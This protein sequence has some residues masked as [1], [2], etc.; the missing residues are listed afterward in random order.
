MHTRVLSMMVLIGSLLCGA[1]VVA[2]QMQGD[3]GDASR[4]TAAGLQVA[5][6][7]PAFGGRDIHVF[8]VAV[9]RPGANGTWQFQ[10]SEGQSGIV[11]WHPGEERTTGVSQWRPDDGSVIVPR[12]AF[13]DD[14]TAVGRPES[15]EEARATA[16]SGRAALE[17]LQQA[18][19]TFPDPVGGDQLQ[20][21]IDHVALTFARAP[22]VAAG[23]VDHQFFSAI[24]DLKR[25]GSASRPEGVSVEQGV[26]MARQRLADAL[27]VERR[28]PVL[29]RDPVRR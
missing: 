3:A 15:I 13:F 29:L 26:A 4:R 11:G 6:G 17:A 22:F 10:G 12:F 20:A 18:F 9:Y 24:V 8:E 5:A 27:A 2:A 14:G 23:R 16:R 19:D 21:L 25:V 1:H 7:P 28:L